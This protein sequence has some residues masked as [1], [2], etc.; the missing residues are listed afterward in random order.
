MGGRGANPPALIGQ[1]SCYTSPLILLGG[2]ARGEQAGLQAN[3]ISQRLPPLGC[4]WRWDQLG[5]GATIRALLLAHEYLLPRR[6]TRR[7]RRSGLWAKLARVPGR[8]KDAIRRIQE[9]PPRA[10]RSGPRSTQRGTSSRRRKGDPWS[11]WRAPGS[12]R[13]TPTCWRT[14]QPPRCGRGARNRS[15]TLRACAISFKCLASS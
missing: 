10:S 12:A 7:A 14:H 5:P 15:S 11:T 6:P 13:P 9:A 1:P 3:R 4:D 8:L 2:Q